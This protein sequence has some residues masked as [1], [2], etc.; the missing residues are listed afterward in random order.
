MLMEI[1]RYFILQPLRKKYILSAA[2][3]GD[4]SILLRNECR[5]V[6]QFRSSSPV[7]FLTKNWR[8]LLAKW[9]NRARGDAGT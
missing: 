6:R 8:D 3:N 4:A 9:Q 2:K 1:L 7:S 5:P